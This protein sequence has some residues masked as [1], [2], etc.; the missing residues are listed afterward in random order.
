[1][2]LEYQDVAVI[3]CEVSLNDLIEF[4]RSKNID[5]L[6]DLMLKYIVEKKLRNVLLDCAAGES[7]E[8]MS[9][10][11]LRKIKLESINAKMESN[12]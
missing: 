7:H 2:M 3:D 4:N 11:E 1:M 10:G 8:I 5:D 12:D 9:I 6:D